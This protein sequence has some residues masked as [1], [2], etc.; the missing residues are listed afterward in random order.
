MITGLGVTLLILLIALS[1]SIVY[2]SW[3]NGIS[4]MP[5]SR[6]ARNAILS[7][8]PPDFEGQIA[9]LGSGWGRLSHTIAKHTP[10]A[11]VQGYETSP[12]PYF[13]SKLYLKAFPL[14]NLSL[15]REDFFKVPLANAQLIVCYLYPKA[16]QKLRSKFEQELKEGTWIISNTFAVPEWRAVKIIQLS[17]IYRTPIYLYQI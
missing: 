10:R 13:W 16:M 1:L 5:S 3:K 6:G 12:V 8:I 14:K 7:M 2:W 9:E 11:S 17:D 15:Y 4:P